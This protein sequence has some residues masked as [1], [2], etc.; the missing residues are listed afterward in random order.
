MD[1]TIL[2]ALGVGAIAAPAIEMLRSLF[3]T[4]RKERCERLFEEM[5]ALSL[6]NKVL[7]KRIN[8]LMSDPST[9]ERD[10]NAV[11]EI[12]SLMRET[13]EQMDE[14]TRRPIEE[15]LE[16]PSERARMSYFTKLLEETKAKSHSAPSSSNQL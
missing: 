6:K 1:P 2:L 9:L 13:L 3:N 14:K 15:G 7:Q 10:P 5:F 11:K 8:V 12:I 16:Q 4:I